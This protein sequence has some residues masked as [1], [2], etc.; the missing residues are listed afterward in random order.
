MLKYSVV[1]DHPDL[2]FDT[3]GLQTFLL[4]RRKI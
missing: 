1:K 2:I 3:I 4:I